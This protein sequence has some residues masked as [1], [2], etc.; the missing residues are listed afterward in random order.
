M[1]FYLKSFI[2]DFFF[3]Y[4]L[5]HNRGVVSIAGHIHPNTHPFTNLFHSF[6]SSVNR[7]PS[8]Q[9]FPLSLNSSLILL[10]QLPLGLPLSLTPSTSETNTFLANLSSFILQTC[11][12]HLS[13]LCSALSTKLFLHSHISFILT[14]LTLSL[15]L[16]PQTA[17]R[18]FISKT[19][20]FFLFLAFNL[21]TSLPY[22]TTGIQHPSS[23]LTFTFLGN[24]PLSQIFLKPPNT[25]SPSLTL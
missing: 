8:S 10:I 7:T 4:N 5:S 17:L 14:F 19:S 15:L 9:F 24:L 1:S 13:L 6:L 18:P 12:N 22:I 20:I 3:I 21:H 2:Y 11:P 16:T 25:F 23:I